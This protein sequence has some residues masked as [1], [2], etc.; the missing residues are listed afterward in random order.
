M[1]KHFYIEEGEGN[2]LIMLHGN[3][4]SNEYFSKQIGVFDEYFRIFA[5]DTRGHGKTPRGEKP[6]TLNQFADDLLDFMNDKKIEKADI[7]G[8]SDGGNIAMIFAIKYP[9]RVDKLVLNGAN[10]NTKGTKWYFQR[11]ID[12][13]YKIGLKKAD[14]SGKRKRKIELLSIMVNEPDIPEEDLKKI[15]AP[16]LVIAGTRDLIKRKHTEEIARLIPDSKLCIIKGNH[17]VA[18]MN[19]REYNKEVLSFLTK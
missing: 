2:P 15:K 5:L 14:K 9:E 16:T 4:E 10:F 6:F 11:L 8:F 12:I 18:R 3:G 13:E 19:P 17:A 1:I 7:L